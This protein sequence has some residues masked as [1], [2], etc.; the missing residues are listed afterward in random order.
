MFDMSKV[1]AGDIC[2]NGHGLQY[3]RGSLFQRS[4]RLPGLSSPKDE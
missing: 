2:K 3:L 4:Y 1:Y